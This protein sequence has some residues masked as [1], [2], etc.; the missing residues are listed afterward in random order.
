MFLCHFTVHFAEINVR[1]IDAAEKEDGW[2]LADGVGE[3]VPFKDVK[4]ALASLNVQHVSGIDPAP[5]NAPR[6]ESLE[7]EAAIQLTGKEV[8]KGQD[9]TIGA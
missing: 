5:Q 8:A 4:I 9:G 2:R 7:K 6:K 3:I 1:F